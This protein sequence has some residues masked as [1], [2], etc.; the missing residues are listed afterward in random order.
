MPEPPR[1]KQ[2]GDEEADI[3]RGFGHGTSSPAEACFCE[4]TNDTN[5]N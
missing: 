1:I 3:T 2:A 4:P 5:E